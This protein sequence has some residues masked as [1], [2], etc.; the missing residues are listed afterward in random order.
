MR[1]IRAFLEKGSP[2]I[3]MTMPLIATPWTPVRCAILLALVVSVP[4]CT[5]PTPESPEDSSATSAL[6]ARS[7]KTTSVVPAVTTSI[8]AS[9]TPAATA[10]APD[11]L[12]DFEEALVGTWQRWQ[13]RNSGSSNEWG[14]YEYL[15]FN[16]DRTA[17]RWKYGQESSSDSDDGLFDSNDYPDWRIT[18]ELYGGNYF[19]V[20]VA[21]A[22]L[23][24]EF[25]FVRNRVYPAGYDT[26]I[27]GPATD[28]KS[29]FVRDGPSY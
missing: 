20:E 26:L 14:Y 7:G 12:T 15:S 13:V 1:L 4:G 24:Y 25:D 22:G 17:C 16:E 9:T 2:S 29:C 5:T 28:A 18:D 8:P 11:P 3:P 21:G 27:F 6:P 10:P 23:D 19:K